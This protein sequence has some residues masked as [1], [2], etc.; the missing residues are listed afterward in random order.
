MGGGSV[1]P[2]FALLKGKPKGKPPLF[3]LCVIVMLF[4]FVLLRFFWGGAC[5]YFGTYTPIISLNHLKLKLGDGRKVTQ[6][7]DPDQ[8]SGKAKGQSSGQFGQA[9]HSKS[10]GLFETT[11]HR[12]KR[13]SGHHTPSKSVA[14]QE[15]RMRS[16]QEKTHR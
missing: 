14:W 8:T 1:P 15:Q 5:P 10:G 9:S 7:L 13:G 12:G 6:V 3:M 4:V 16:C 11:C 2:S